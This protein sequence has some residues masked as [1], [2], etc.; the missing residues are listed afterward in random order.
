MAVCYEYSFKKKKTQ[1]MTFAVN[2]PSNLNK[3]HI[4]KNENLNQRF[5]NSANKFLKSDI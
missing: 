2:V 1:F 5:S 3:S 4:F